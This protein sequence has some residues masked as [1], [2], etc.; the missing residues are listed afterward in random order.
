MD[1]DYLVTE[2]FGLEPLGMGRGASG[3]CHPTEV[4]G[5]FENEIYSM[6]LKLTVAVHSC[7]NCVVTVDVA[8]GTA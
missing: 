5:N 2:M 7:V 6:M 3:G 4:F 8:I 1:A